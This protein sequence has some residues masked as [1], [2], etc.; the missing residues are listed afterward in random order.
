MQ[1]HFCSPTPRG[2]GEAPLGQYWWVWT[3]RQLLARRS[4]SGSGHPAQA[5]AF[6]KIALRISPAELV[7][8]SHAHSPDLASL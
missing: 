4:A 1:N 6:R 3:L 8:S 7:P 5:L 2:E